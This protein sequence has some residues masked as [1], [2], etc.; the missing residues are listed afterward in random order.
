VYEAHYAFLLREAE[1]AVRSVHDV[2]REGVFPRATW[3]RLLGESG[4]D[5]RLATRTIDGEDYDTFVAVK[6]A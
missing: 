4:L 1:G 5:P 3:L 2:H 6:R